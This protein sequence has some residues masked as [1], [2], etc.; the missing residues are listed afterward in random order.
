MRNGYLRNMS[1][2]CNMLTPSGEQGA[3]SP[4]IVAAAPSR[5][6]KPEN[7][8]EITLEDVWA[9]SRFHGNLG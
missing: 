5:L 3:S 8:D 9:R 2:S 7:R 1:R 6:A 4:K